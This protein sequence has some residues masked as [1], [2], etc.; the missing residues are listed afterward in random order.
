MKCSWT[1][2]EYAIQPWITSMSVDLK[3][4]CIGLGWD[5][6]PAAFW[7]EVGPFRIDLARDEPWPTNAK[8]IP[9]WTVPMGQWVIGKLEIRIEI[10]WNIWRF[11]VAIA[12]RHDWGLYCG[13]INCQAEYGKRYADH[14]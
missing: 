9:N 6:R 4:W 13:P 7:I 5:L 3:S 8:E 10:D 1:L 14:H 2:V 11:G 12:D